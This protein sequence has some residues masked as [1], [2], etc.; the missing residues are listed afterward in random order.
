M[1]P[2][3]GCLQES[4]GRDACMQEIIGYSG[5]DVVFLVV[6]EK[7]AM[8]ASK[9]AATAVAEKLLLVL[10]AQR[11]LGKDAYPLTLEQLVDLADLQSSPEL[12]GKAL[13]KKTF[14]DRVAITSKS[15]PNG[16]IALAED[17]E[18]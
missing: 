7:C 3:R 1:R 17:V 9:D 13:A 6:T 14:K 10:E 11:S 15:S 4:R 16:L 12:V 5:F 2:S 18:Q 8:A